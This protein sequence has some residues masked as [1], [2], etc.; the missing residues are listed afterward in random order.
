MMITRFTLA[1]GYRFYNFTN[2]KQKTI[3]MFNWIDNN[4]WVIPAL[5]LILSIYSFFRAY[6]QWKSGSTWDE[7]D[8]FGKRTIRES[9]EKV[10]FLSIGATRFGIVLLLAAIA[11]WYLMQQDK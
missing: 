1:I 6:K 11:I 8:Q 3:F 5:A 7:V 4:M 10:K 9:K 2:Y